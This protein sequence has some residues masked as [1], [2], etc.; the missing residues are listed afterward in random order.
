MFPLIFDKNF[1]TSKRAPFSKHLSS[2]AYLN[3]TLYEDA[4]YSAQEV[5]TISFNSGVKGLRETVQNIVLHA[6]LYNNGCNSTNVISF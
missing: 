3:P 1:G 6:D 2:S 5:C 4:V